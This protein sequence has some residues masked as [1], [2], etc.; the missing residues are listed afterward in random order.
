MSALPPKADIRG[1]EFISLCVALSVLRQ[2]NCEMASIA[3]GLPAAPP[4]RHD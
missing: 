4:L 3:V 1:Q 2:E